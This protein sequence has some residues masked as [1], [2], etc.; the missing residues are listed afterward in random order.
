MTD[1]WQRIEKLYHS[2][3]ELNEPQ[4][5]AYLEQ[6]CSGDEELRREVP[7]TRFEFK[8]LSNLNN[9]CAGQVRIS[10]RLCLTAPV[11]LDSVLTFLAGNWCTGFFHC[12]Q[13]ALFV[14]NQPSQ[15]SRA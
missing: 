2:V 8:H 1:R 14:P 5:K 3:L 11:T 9:F 15:W 13:I 7:R 10:S 6:T 4:R 12:P